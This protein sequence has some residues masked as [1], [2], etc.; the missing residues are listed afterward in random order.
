MSNLAE[1]IEDAVREI[2]ARSLGREVASVSLSACLMEDLGAE[3][4][5]F[6]DIVF[7]L[8]RAFE[9]EITRGQ[10]EAAARGD[11]SDEEF[12]PGGV[13]SDAALERVRALM[14]ESAERVRAGLR[15]RQILG[16]FT[17]QTLVNIVR[18][19]LA[20]KQG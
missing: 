14:P 10:M 17:V 3:S 12:A 19:Q 8:E 1:P 2:V 20:A 9:I 16:L 15:P 5:D 4:L 13:L 6:L 18:G 7:M 11:M